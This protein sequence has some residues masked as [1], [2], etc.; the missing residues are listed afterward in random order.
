VIIPSSTE[1]YLSSW[2]FADVDVESD[3]IVE[4]ITAPVAQ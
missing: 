4:F 1:R 2:L 3:N